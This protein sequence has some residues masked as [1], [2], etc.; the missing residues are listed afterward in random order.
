VLRAQATALRVQAESLEALASTLAPAAESDPFL[1]L[2][3]GAKL[4]GTSARA[5]R[6]AIRRSELE[7][8]GRPVVV[9][10]SAVIA[11][12]EGRKVRPVVSET[13]TDADAYTALV[14][15]P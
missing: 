10:R 5:L 2:R 15:A 1:S 3:D 6:D 14:G 11:W 7:G 9:R 8:F 13:T 4:A 12:L